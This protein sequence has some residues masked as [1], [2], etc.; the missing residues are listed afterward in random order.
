MVL[1]FLWNRKCFGEPGEDEG[2]QG[3]GGGFAAP[4]NRRLVKKVRG[5]SIVT[6]RVEQLH[7]AASVADLAL[8]P[9]AAAATQRSDGDDAALA[10]V[11][12]SKIGRI[13]QNRTDRRSQVEE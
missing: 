13:N 1:R 12:C 4:Q 10:T 11:S 3:A 6:R 7:T 2:Q 5:D 8:S 9:G